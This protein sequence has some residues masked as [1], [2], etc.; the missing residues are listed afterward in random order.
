MLAWGERPLIVESQC[1]PMRRSSGVFYEWMIRDWLERNHL[2]EWWGTRS[3]KW[4]LQKVK[5]SP[6]WAIW[7]ISRKSS[8]M[9]GKHIFLL[10]HTRHQVFWWAAFEEFIKNCRSYILLATPGQWKNCDIYQHKAFNYRSN[11]EW[12]RNHLWT[13][14]HSWKWKMNPDLIETSAVR[15]KTLLSFTSPPITYLMRVFFL[16]SFIHLGGQ[17]MTSWVNML[18]R[19]KARVTTTCS[20]TLKQ[21]TQESQYFYLS[22]RSAESPTPSL[23][24]THTPLVGW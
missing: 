18:Q 14:A 20:S 23:T 15:S 6:I 5:T 8:T 2:N 10:L 13:R 11:K 24:H 19:N 12:V 17:K 7:S 3:V 22:L 21:A 1:K 9:R 4:I 16:L